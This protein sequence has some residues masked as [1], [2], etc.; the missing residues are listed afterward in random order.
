MAAELYFLGR[1]TQVP[2]PPV[3][4]IVPGYR[5]KNLQYSRFVSYKIIS[6]RIFFANKL[7]YFKNIV[8]L[9]RYIFPALFWIS[10][11]TNTY[12]D[13]QGSKLKQINDL[14][15]ERNGYEDGPCHA[16]CVIYCTLKCVVQSLNS[17]DLHQSIPQ[18]F[19]FQCH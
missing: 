6:V 4:T 15:N 3:T 17:E 19:S 2:P 12:N 11:P 8:I 18:N 1:P 16:Y 7:T 13:Q 14:Q 5:V 9:S 10:Q